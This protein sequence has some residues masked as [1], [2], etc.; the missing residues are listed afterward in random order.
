MSSI[1]YNCFYIA[2]GIDEVTKVLL[3]SR[4][5]HFVIMDFEI[6]AG[7]KCCTNMYTLLHFLLLRVSFLSSMN[8]FLESDFFLYA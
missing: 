3:F 2:C 6:W 1:C 5:F 4:I 8:A 7:I